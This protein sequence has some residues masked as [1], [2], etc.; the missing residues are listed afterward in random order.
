MVKRIVSVLLMSGA[1]VVLTTATQAAQVAEQG[2]VRDSH[3]ERQSIVGSW[4]GT[5]D[6]G[7]RI[8]ISFTSDGIAFSSVQGEVK[9][10]LPVLSP[11]H[12]AWTRVGGRL[13]ALTQVGVVYD[14]QT[15]ADQGAAKIRALLTLDAAGDHLSGDAKVD[16]FSPDGTLLVTFSHTLRFT[17]IQVE[18]FD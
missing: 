3:D 7:E 17:R 5:L 8:V 4:T 18:P 2:S 10:T 15:G 14:L 13:F 6:N 12:G 1:I 16:V 9:L 11:A